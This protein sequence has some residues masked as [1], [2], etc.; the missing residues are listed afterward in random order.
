[1]L[2]YIPIQL[3]AD[4]IFS[5]RHYIKSLHLDIVMKY[6]SIHSFV[7]VCC[8]DRGRDMLEY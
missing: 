6:L 2:S 5:S 4:A 1:M 8:V 7:Y 3:Q